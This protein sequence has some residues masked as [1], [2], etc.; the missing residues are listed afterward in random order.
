MSDIVHVVCPHCD[1][2]NRV[3]KG[4]LEERG[5]CGRCGKPLFT[6]RPV[7]LDSRRFAR[8]LEKSDLPLLVDFWAEWCGPCRLMAP[9]FEEAA[10]RLEPELRLVRV[11]TEAEPGLAAELSIRSIPTLVLFRGGREVARQAGAAPLPQLLDWV[12]RAVPAAA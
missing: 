11:D 12:R 7:A 3:P 4:R 6:G 5:R 8:H 1:T 2:A 9:V 10:V